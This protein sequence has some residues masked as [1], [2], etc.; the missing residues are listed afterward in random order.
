[1]GKALA[2]SEWKMLTEKRGSRDALL[3]TGNASSSTGDLRFLCLMLESSPFSNSHEN[4]SLSGELDKTG[5][6]GEVCTRIR[7]RCVGGRLMASRL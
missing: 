6:M 3:A 4:R 1:M 2:G 5:L 7:G